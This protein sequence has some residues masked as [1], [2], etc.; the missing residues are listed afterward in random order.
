MDSARP[1]LVERPARRRR[2]TASMTLRKPAPHLM[3][4]G[5][6]LSEQCVLEPGTDSPLSREPGLLYDGRSC[7]IGQ[8]KAMTYEAEAEVR[9]TSVGTKVLIFG[10]SILAVLGSFWAIVWF[11]RA[12]VEAPRV[13]IPA[14][15]ALAASESRPA[16]APEAKP[17]EAAAPAPAVPN[18]VMAEAKPTPAARAPIAVPAAS[19]E[20]APSPASAVADRWGPVNEIATR[21]AAPVMAPPAAP[22][23]RPGAQAEPAPANT[24]PAALATKAREN[25]PP[26]DDVVEATVPTIEG[27]APLPRRK[28][29][30]T[31]AAKRI[32]PPLP[33]PRPD[34]PAPQSVWT[35]VPSTDE[36]FAGQQ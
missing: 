26:A 14:P 10:C 27:P 6:R 16:P 21:S 23:E 30:V 36:R 28:P 22:A 7:V 32:D 31:A 35:G 9:R 3:R 15:M 18:P 5:H 24:A 8:P 11:I 19:P 1:E 33:R 13:G 34:G 12:Y 25:D 2:Q 4:G 20:P 17:S 29:T